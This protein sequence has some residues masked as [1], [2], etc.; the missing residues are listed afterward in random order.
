M[1]TMP[2]RRLEDR[3]RELCMRLLV[4]KEPDWSDTARELQA[5]LQEH[6]MRI[7]NLTTALII[8]GKSVTERRKS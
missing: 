7:A 8:A 5:S 3:I 4:E 1:M 2:P 6:I